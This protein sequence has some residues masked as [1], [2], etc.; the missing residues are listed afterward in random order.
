MGPGPI[1]NQYWTA[2][3]VSASHVVMAI[4]RLSAHEWP[5]MRAAGLAAAATLDAVEAVLRPGLSTLDIDRFVRLDTQRWGG[6]PSQLGYHGFPA[7]VCVSVNDVVCHGIPSDRVRLRDG[8][9]VNVDITTYLDG[10]HGDTSRTFLIGSVHGNEALHVVQ[11]ARRCLHAGIGEVR[12]GVRLGDIGAAIEEVASA[13]R[14][15]VVRD[16]GGHGIGRVMHASPHV[17]H[18]GRRG[19]GLRLREGMAITIEPM[20]NFGA[21]D[22]RCADDGWTVRTVDGSLSA[23]FEHTL[24]V[25]ASGCEVL[26][27]SSTG[28]SPKAPPATFGP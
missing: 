20:I 27:P 19:Q 10:Y 24:L 18:F 23:Q 13:A 26:T 12:D 8:D 7:A 16:Y 9:I 15:S 6:T 3:G 25:T 1:P 21:P 11:T 22:T 2:K 5:P 14:C 4:S 28:G 17:P